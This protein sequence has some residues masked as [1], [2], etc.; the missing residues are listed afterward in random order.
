VFDLVDTTYDGTAW[1]GSPLVGIVSPALHLPRLIL[2]PR[3]DLEQHGKSV[4]VLATAAE[5]AVDWMASHSGFVRLSFAEYPA[6]EER[7]MV[8]GCN[9]AETRQFLSAIRL[10]Q[11]ISLERSYKIEAAGDMFTINGQQSLPNRKQ[12]STWGEDIEMLVA[13]AQ[14]LLFWFQDLG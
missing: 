4:A 1:I 8:F 6:F 14:K 11:L 10:S 12:K 9:E 13:D 3:L 7:F 2:Q 5:K